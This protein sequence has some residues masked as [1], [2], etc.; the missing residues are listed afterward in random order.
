M[1]NLTT[2]AVVDAQERERRK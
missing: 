2:F 1:V